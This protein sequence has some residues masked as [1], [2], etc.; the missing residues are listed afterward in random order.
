MPAFNPPRQSRSG[1]I[2]LLPCFFLSPLA[3]KK[4]DEIACQLAQHFSSE[5]SD[6]DGRVFS[7]AVDQGA[8]VN[9]FFR[10][11][12][13]YKKLLAPLHSGDLFKVPSKSDEGLF[14]VEYSQPNTHKELHIGHL[15]NICF[16]PGFG[17]LV[18]EA[19]FFWFA[20][21]LFPGIQAHILPSV[22]GI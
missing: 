11:D 7:K 20:P 17:D 13:L 22:C 8:Y 9:F 16:W 19:G 2:G 6:G 21:A 10:D 15:R 3:K 14:L 1:G 12:F 4:P 18:K 5:G